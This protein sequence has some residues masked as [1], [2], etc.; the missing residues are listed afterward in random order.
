[1]TIPRLL[2]LVLISLAFGTAVAAGLAVAG[3]PE[4]G[5]PRG[6]SAPPA[7]AAPAA[8]PAARPEVAAADL[9]GAWD[10]ARAAAWAGDDDAALAALYTPGSA[11]G[12]HDR[13]ML[14][15]WRL[16]GL[17]VTGL[18]MQVLVLGV[19]DQDPDRLVLDVTD[20]VTAAQV[21]GAGATLR[22]PRDAASRRTVVLRLVDGDWRVASVRDAG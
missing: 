9:L 19:V 16:R 5:P 22:L 18:R 11:A 21:G 17:R 14:R 12:R 4:P 13:A 2:L 1:M 20:R 3:G 15:S 8:P 7:P 10:R 6:A